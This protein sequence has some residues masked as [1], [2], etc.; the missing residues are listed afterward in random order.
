MQSRALVLATCLPAL[1]FAG[2]CQ[3]LKECGQGYG[4]C[5]TQYTCVDESPGSPGRCELVEPG[6]VPTDRTKPKSCSFVQALF[7]TADQSFFGNAVATNG[8]SVLIGAVGSESPA[9]RAY[10]YDLTA[11]QLMPNASFTQQVNAQRASVSGSFGRSLAFLGNQAVV[12]G[13]KGWVSFQGSGTSWTYRAS[14]M[15][16]AGEGK[17]VAT[18]GT[19]V[20]LGVLGANT[21]VELRQLADGA[22]CKTITPSGGQPLSGFGEALAIAG[23]T[24]FIGAYGGGMIQQMALNCPGGSESA[25]KIQSILGKAGGFGKSLGVSG[26]T[27]V[28]GTPSLSN[29]GPSFF[30]YVKQSGGDWQP[31]VNGPSRDHGSGGEVELGDALAIDGDLVVVGA[32]GLAGGSGGATV[33]QRQGPQWVALAEISAEFP[34]RNATEQLTDLG[35]SVAVSGGLVVV[36]APASTTNLVPTGAALVYRCQ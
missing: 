19:Y 27:L 29:V 16:A 21:T 35:R 20:A 32:P 4:T 30:T 5:P 33:Y 23:G 22:L 26:S 24:L 34:G 18:D 3:R 36:G 13:L 8:Q 15:L 11:G 12:A 6:S 14:G 10:L 1:L 7:G 25:E 31:E 17:A 2:S 9:G 28:G